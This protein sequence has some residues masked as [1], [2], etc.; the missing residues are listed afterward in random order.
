MYAGPLPTSPTLSSPPGFSGRGLSV[1]V[2]ELDESTF[3]RALAVLRQ[4]LFTFTP[5]AA[6]V[7]ELINSNSPL[8]T[9]LPSRPLAILL[10]LS[11]RHHLFPALR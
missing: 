10:I 11:Y 7:E 9:T 1:P 6:L 8:N 5:L 2:S 4:K 3:A